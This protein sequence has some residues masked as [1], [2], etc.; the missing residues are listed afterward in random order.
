MKNLIISLLLCV[1]F[2]GI[3]QKLFLIEREISTSDVPVT[4]LV[5]NVTDNFDEVIDNYKKFVKEEYD[6]KVKKEDNNMYEVEEV[7]LPHISVKRGD[8]RTYLI[9]TDSMNLIGIAF[10]LGYDMFLNSTEYPDEMMQLKNLSVAFLEYH[11][12]AYYYDKIES[13]NKE[14]K[15]L[16]KDLNQN[17][18]KISSLK[19]KV[20]SLDKKASKEDDETKKREIASDKLETENE[21]DIIVSQLPE[22]RDN[23]SIKEDEVSILKEELNIYHQQISLL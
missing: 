20:I 1:P 4:A 23:L 3:A 5:M 21:I 18:N 10:I 13:L 6:L 12:H 16:I 7:S 22:M 8:L 9:P 2:T 14:L 17:E 11:Y 19:K 15:G